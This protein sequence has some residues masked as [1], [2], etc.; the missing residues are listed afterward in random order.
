MFSECGLAMQ[1]FD[2]V[3]FCDY[4]F[5]V[6]IRMFFLLLRL[7]YGH[8]TAVFSSINVQF[9]PIYSLHVK[10]VFGWSTFS[11]CNKLWRILHWQ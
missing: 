2:C 10:Y 9:F 6:F 7:L 5:T 1:L 11:G 3:I 4:Y 8:F